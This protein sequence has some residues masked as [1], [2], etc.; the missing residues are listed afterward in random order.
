MADARRWSCWHAG[1]PSCRCGAGALM[2]CAGPIPHVDGFG[3]HTVGSD[4][5]LVTAAG[6]QCCQL[7]LTAGGWQRCQAVLSFSRSGGFANAPM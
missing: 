4:K 5:L 3:L 7:H 2:L 6:E 1:L